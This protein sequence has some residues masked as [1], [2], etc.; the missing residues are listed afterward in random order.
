MTGIFAYGYYLGHTHA[1]TNPDE[2]KFRRIRKESM[3]RAEE[4]RQEKLVKK[5]RKKDGST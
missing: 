2:V 1:M 4:R 3:A 5:Y